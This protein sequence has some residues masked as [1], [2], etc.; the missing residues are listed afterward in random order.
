MISVLVASTLVSATQFLKAL[1]MGGMSLDSHG[2]RPVSSSAFNNQ[3]TSRNL[4]STKYYHHR[5]TINQTSTVS[6]LMHLPSNTV[7]YLPSK[8]NWNIRVKLGRF[9]ESND[10][11][12]I[13]MQILTKYIAERKCNPFFSQRIQL[14]IYLAMLV[15]RKCCIAPPGDL[16]IMMA[17]KW[18][19]LQILPSRLS[20]CVFVAQ[21]SFA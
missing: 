13:Q 12:E 21:A 9:S 10:T 1:Y 16:G 11:L 8:W 4:S 7:Y 20:R 2:L 18:R 15:L 5:A 17:F 19:H 6:R 3:E 14:C